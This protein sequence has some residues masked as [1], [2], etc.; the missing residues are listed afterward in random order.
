MTATTNAGFDSAAAAPV[1]GALYLV[2]M[3]FAGGTLYYINWPHDVTV[4]AQVYTGLGTLG[5]V[6][7]I[8]ESEDGGSQ[9]VDLELSQ[10]NVSMLALALGNV[11]N[12]QDRPVR[13][14]LALTDTAFVIS[15]DPVLRFSGFM[16][17]VSVK[18]DGESAKIIM[19][20]TSGGADVRK[21]PTALRMNDAQH[22]ARYP[23]ERLFE[24]A[25][26]LIGQPKRWLS[27]RFQASLIP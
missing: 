13:V 22:Q 4:G 14:Y 6:G 12:Y 1:V 20:C 15:G 11:A 7:P 25:P 9:T 19:R 27:V 16:D 3:D 18:R 17:T 8:R 23:G 24:Y 21:S 2:E 10:V 26:D 5:A